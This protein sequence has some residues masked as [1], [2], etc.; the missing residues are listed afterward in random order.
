MTTVDSPA[1][2][3][4]SN[5][6]L[7]PPARSKWKWVIG[8][9]VALV[10]VILLIRWIWNSL[11]TV[12]TDDAYVNG[13]A[14]FVAARV[15][16]QVL[17]V[18]VDDN[19]RVHKGDLLVQLD[20]EPYQVQVNIARS[21]VGAA[22]S[23]VAVAEAQVRGTEGQMRSLRFS[24]ERSI[25]D[26]DDKV[27]L[28]RS[29]VATLN[30][31]KAS[32][33]KAQ[34]DYDR[35]VPLVKSGA[36]STE[37][38]DTRKEALLVAQAQE[39]ETLQS[40]YEQRVALGLPSTPIT[41]DDLAEVP[42]D[43]DQSF[44]LVRE[45]EMSLMQA[46]AQV[47]V[48]E[49]FNISPKQVIANFYKRDPNGDIDRIYAGLRQNAPSVK[50]AQSKLVEAQRNLD[51]AELNL[52]YCNVVSEID[53]VVTRRD[54]NPGNNIQAGQS[55]MAVRSLTD[56]WIDANFKETQLSR[57]RIGQPVDLDVDMYGSRKRFQGRISGF[58][59]GTGSTLALLP[60]ENATGNFVKVVQRLPVRIDVTDY[61]P[62]QVP[63]FIGLSVEPVVH[64]NEEATGPN[65]GKFLQPY[66]PT[67]RPT[68][69]TAT[70]PLSTSPTTA[71]GTQP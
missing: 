30:S 38:L 71:P 26:V 9:L 46:A 16:G 23:D 12:S 1:T 22:Q 56:I 29:K 6:S 27:A 42:P 28:L 14:T 65:A 66:E 68:T 37:E 51:Q 43:L 63:L 17:R 33:D 54:V 52:R 41:G 58:T 34:A 3:H 32:L 67:S 47:G 53:G 10:V 57:L 50:Q 2:V 60:A 11:G 69:T 48:E 64:V 49:S 59:M 62:D 20:P 36:V 39:Q 4:S 21:V 70:A 25:E 44:S 24:L 18:L 31:R 5:P 55:L 35:A 45:A 7:S 13:H 8:G 19:N 15:P 40:V 61:D